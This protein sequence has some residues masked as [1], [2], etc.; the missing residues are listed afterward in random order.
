MDSGASKHICR[1]KSWFKHLNYGGAPKRFKVASNSYTYSEGVGTVE[2]PLWDVRRGSVVNVILNDVYYLPGQP[3]NLLS[4]HQCVNSLGFNNPNFI[5]SEWEHGDYCYETTLHG[6]LMYLEGYEEPAAVPAMEDGGGQNRENGNWAIKLSEYRKFGKL[7]GNPD[8]GDF[9]TDLFTDG[10]PHGVG[11]CMAKTGFSKQ[12]CAFHTSFHGKYFWANPVYTNKF[13]FKTLEKM[14]K[15][16]AKDPQHTTQMVVV[17]VI[18][19]ASW[20]HFT[21]YFDRVHTY[22]VGTQLFTM[23]TNESHNT[24]Q[25]QPAGGE[26]HGD[27]CFVDGI[28]YEVTVLHRDVHTSMKV[29]E[30]FKAHLIFGHY[31]A[32]HISVLLDNDVNMGLKLNKSILRKC[33]PPCTCNICLLAKLRRPGPFRGGAMMRRVVLGPFQ[34]LVSDVTGAISPESFTGYQYVIHFTCVLTRWT[35]IFFMTRKYEVSFKFTECLGYIKKFGYT[36]DKLLLRTDN[37]KEYIEGD[38]H[39]LCMT[40]GV[41]REV[42]SAYMHEENALAEVVFRDLSNGARALMLMCDLPK[43][44]WPLAY[45]HF[46]FL[47]NRMPNSNN[48]WKI[49]YFEVVKEHYDYSKLQPFGCDAY[50]WVDP[51]RRSG[52]LANKSE[53][54]IYVGNYEWTSAYAC[55]DPKTWKVKRKGYPQF[56]ANFSVMGNKMSNWDLEDTLVLDAEKDLYSLPKPFFEELDTV[57]ALKIISH[58][59]WYNEEDHETEALV[60]LEELKSITGPFP[61]YWVPLS[62]YLRKSDESTHAERFSNFLGYMKGFL[63]NGN[64]NQYY[65][66]F[67]EVMAFSNYDSSQKLYSAV[68]VSHDATVESVETGTEFGVVFDAKCPILNGFED[69]SAGKISWSDVFIA[70]PLVS[71]VAE[72]S[73]LS[74]YVPVQPLNWRHAMTMPD[75]ELWIEAREKEAKAMIDQGVMQFQEPPTSRVV[76]IV[77][78]IAVLKLKWISTGV[79]DKRRYRICARGC[80]QTLGVSYDD[81][82]APTAQLTSIRLILILCLTFSLKAHHLDVA[83]AFMNSPLKY[84]IW[85][86]LPD[87]WPGRGNFKH[88]KLLKSLYGLKQAAKDWYDLQDEFILSFDSRF[89]RS[90]SEPCMYYLVTDSLMAFIL[91]YVDD[92]IMATNSEKFYEKFLRA[93]STRFQVNDLGEVSHLLQMKVS[94]TPKGIELSQESYINE[95]VHRFGLSNAKP[96]DTPLPHDICLEKCLTDPDPKIPFRSLLGC[97]LWIARCSRPEIMASVIYMAQFTCAYDDK[98]FQSLKRILRYLKGT[99]SYSLLLPMPTKLNCL[100]MVVYYDSDWAGDNVDRK[101]VSGHC[102]FLNGCLL[103]FG[104]Q[105]QS[106]QAHSSTEAEYV[107]VAEACKS[108]RHLVMMVDEVMNDRYKVEA[109]VSVYVDNQGAIFIADND[110]NNKRSKHIDIKFHAIRDWVKKKLYDLYYVATDDNTADIFT[111]ALAILKFSKF[112]TD[113]HVLDC[114]LD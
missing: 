27:R 61:K 42:I 78:T 90:I 55:M 18:P 22:P 24:T 9:D 76:D 62:V 72:V 40:H 92:Y 100:V 80:F 94:W 45:R 56:V 106:T 36:C 1:E 16:F 69:I 37:A 68:I 39:D 6:G 93:F 111:K 13:L 26:A 46:C 110:V 99:S 103:E 7:Y 30:H 60:E 8:T 63:Y 97:L 51:G 85:I 32:K 74:T 101:S 77:D 95:I 33:N 65:P 50:C 86:K 14:T 15:D 57:H 96:Q 53:R 21:K 73:G 12:N 19:E 102:M 64:I 71:K 79:V 38:M 25:P 49:P 4:V 20:W 108:G 105:K 87:D 75:R 2:I 5:N 84:D 112:R 58:R 66:L 109:P 67:S 81:V 113:L 47:R 82:F 3:F 59:S 11:D 10:L 89:K 48:H 114:S 17:P 28:P 104:S 23:P 31:S 29:D 35:F 98:H 34:Y 107:A 88:A 43:Q 91:V 44:L 83:V 70:T 41:K 54:L 52:K